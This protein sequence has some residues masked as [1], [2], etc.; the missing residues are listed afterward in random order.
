MRL[1][2][3]VWG[4]SRMQDYNVRLILPND[5]I[6]EVVVP[7]GMTL[8]GL[9]KKNAASF[10]EPVVLAKVD[11]KLRELNKEIKSDMEVSFISMSEK[12]GK[13]TYRRSLILL[14]QKALDNFYG[15]L[16]D[17]STC[18]KI[19][20]SLGQ[21]YYC[22]FAGANKRELSE[23]DLLAVK[24]EMNRLVDADCPIKKVSYKTTDAEQIFKD[25]GM[26]QKERLL[27][28]RRSS[29]VNLYEL[30]GMQDYF[31]GY[32]VPST[33]YLKWFDL[34]KYENG[35]VITFPN[36]VYNQPEKLETS[37]KLHRTLYEAREWSSMMEIGSVG[38]LND[39]IASGK[40]QSLILTH[41]A[42]ME[43]RIGNL[44]QQIVEHPDI[45]FVMIAGPS[46][47]GKTSFANRLSIQL[48]AKGVHPYPISLDDYYA[49]R[50]KCPKN[51][52]GS[53]DFECLEA[54]DV[55]QFNQ[56]MVR[57]LQGECV[58]MPSLNFKTG[59]R[60]YRGHSIQLGENDLL[61]IEGI[62]GLND[63]LSYSLPAESKF[64]IYISALTQ[65]NIDEHNPLP[66]TDGRLI[67][68]MVRDAR[69]RGTNAQETIRMWPSVRAG[70]EK[71]IFPFQESAD[72]I[73]NSALLYELAVLKVYAEPILFQIPCDSEEYPEAKRLLKFLDYFLPL[74][75]EDISRNSLVREFV[76]GSCFNV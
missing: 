73:F 58:D 69:T 36:T 74:P 41:E 32:M 11:G 8:E 24:A 37:A 40:G 50:E 55:E 3:P 12:D 30:N 33:G 9:Y 66:T 35:F 20:Y 14:L 56:D 39:A 57:L 54:L 65:L 47:S 44:A 28:Y 7:E 4:K 63:K 34:E 59:K 67:R 71:Y 48:A 53:Y 31:Y 42:M 23:D 60:E 49:D 13:R 22:E 19:L 27:H 46:S 43:Q 75:V 51:P 29:R 25:L 16:A 61:V 10:A 72:V 62:H 38:E 15:T 76:G 64:R 2:T 1:P 45:K 18:V 6:R 17:T 68:R 21:G 70:E 52:D 26:V 5:E